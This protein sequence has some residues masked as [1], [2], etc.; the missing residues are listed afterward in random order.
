MNCP[1]EKEPRLL[2]DYCA[3]RLAPDAA[4]AVK[5]HMERCPECRRSA[6]AQSAVW[7][8]LDGVDAPPLSPAFDRNVW[9]RIEQDGARR[10]WWT[11]AWPAMWRPAVPVALACV[12]SFFAFVL[13]RPRPDPVPEEARID[14]VEADRIESALDDIDMLRQLAAVTE[15]GRVM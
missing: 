15:E 4:A 13:E 2:L 1:F 5:E 9:A 11:P 8:A 7:A 14:A 6:A 3:G 10:R 12:L